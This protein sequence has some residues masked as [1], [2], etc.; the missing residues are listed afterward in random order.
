VYPGARR[1]WGFTRAAARHRVTTKL[2]EY[3]F[4]YFPLAAAASRPKSDLRRSQVGILLDLRLPQVGEKREILGRLAAAASLLI[5]T[6]S[7]EKNDMRQPQVG[8]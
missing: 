5:R 8:K 4:I 7:H 1:R 3:I 6:K 2:Y